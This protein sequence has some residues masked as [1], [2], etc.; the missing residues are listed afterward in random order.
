MT[1]KPI[2]KE[3]KRIF[4][5]NR[6]Q[7]DSQELA[8]AKAGFSLRSAKRI[9]TDIC[10]RQPPLSSRKEN[11]NLR[12]PFQ[13]VWDAD[14]VPLLEKSP[15]LQAVTLLRYLQDLYEGKYP[16][17]LL[18][19]LQRRVRLWKGVC[20]PEKEVIFRQNHPPGWQGLSDFTNCNELQ[21][22]ISGEPFPHLLYHFWLAFSTWEYA[23]VVIGG[24]SF[25]ALA[26]GLQ[27][28][29]W[30]LGGVPQTHRTDS[31]S[32][33]YKNRSKETKDDFTKAYDDFC[34]H[35]S[36]EPT[37]NNKGVKH[38]NGS[39]EVS[40]YHLKSRLDQALMIRGS[41]DFISVEEYRNFVNNHI[42]KHN[43][44]I[45]HLIE[46]ERKYLKSLPNFKTKDFDMQF[47][48]VAT[49]GIVTI[50]QVRYSV[51][52]RLIGMQ[53]K[54]HIYDDHI[55]CFLGCTSVI[56]LK[57]LRWNRGS[58]PASIDYRHL[59]GT[60][61]RK[62]QAFRNY[63][64]KDHLYPT[65]AFKA[66]W[67][68]LD[69]TLDERSACREYVA[70]LKLA[71]ENEESLISQC[72][73]NLIESQNLPRASEIESLLSIKKPSKNVQVTVNHSNLKSYNRLL[74]QKTGE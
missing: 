50:R 66:A 62:P 46:E 23:S 47:V 39:V 38:E 57:R 70:I 64:F 6:K 53:L 34:E 1:G 22:T 13:E 71:A 33:A 67:E 69:Q 4:M 44:R 49:T 31:L 27:D 68:I 61:S 40:H 45:Q 16:D 19:T 7:G 10:L 42:S 24:E 14:L 26:E 28:A 41:R 17:K 52:S 58:R 63:Q 25:T 12:D 37:R 74:N 3:Q 35:Y 2:T 32:A 15:H 18:R 65:F 60:L 5:K 59:I 21:V 43:S 36:M 51:P 20:G 8:A 72:L 73:E 54:A 9:E 29:L 48:R 30:A 56:S 55:E 11:I